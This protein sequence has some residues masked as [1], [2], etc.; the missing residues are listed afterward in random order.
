MLFGLVLLSDGAGSLY[1][2][3][4]IV[5]L[6]YHHFGHTTPY[7]TSVTPEQFDRHLRYLEENG[8]LVWSLEK[9]VAHLQ[10]GLD[11]P[12]KCIAIT[13]DDA[14]RSIYTEAFP[15]LKKLKW[16]FTV[17]VSTKGVDQG[18]NIHLTW[19]QMREM[20]SYGTTFAMHTHTHAHLIRKKKGE[21]QA[22][23]K[24]RVTDEILI[25]QKRL[26]EELGAQSRL[27]AY[28]FGEFSNELKAIVRD[29]GFI[30]IGQQSG[31]IWSGSDFGVLSRFP[32]SGDYA[33]LREFKVKVKSLPLPV[34]AVEPDDT[35]LTGGN[36]RP[37]L[38]L[39]LAT[40]DYNIDSLACFASGQG[41]IRL[42]WIDRKNRVLECV[43]HKPLPLGRSR[44]NCTASHLN[45]KRHF[46]YS[47]PW[48]R[49]TA[50][51]AKEN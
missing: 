25:S 11:V 23:W 37:V 44:Y 3:S 33:N 12:A 50:P 22:A 17:F 47:H 15:R 30:G 29:L 1:G 51:A 20:T 13:I 18:R 41:K 40:G 35:V 2:G 49:I 14:Y 4:H 32:V 7:S 27:F 21:S 19:G 6:Q 45:S 9:S 5:V 48:I 39:R 36:Q 24:I 8:Y 16:P 10:Q 42:R 43:S 31:A 38:R 28:P 46:W 26:K 34:I